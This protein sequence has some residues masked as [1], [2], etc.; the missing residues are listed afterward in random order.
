M[1]TLLHWKCP[2]AHQRC[3]LWLNLVSMW[4]QHMKIWR[5]VI[6]LSMCICQVSLDTAGV[7]QV[8]FLCP[9]SAYPNVFLHVSKF[10]LRYA[11]APQW[12]TK[13]ISLKYKAFKLLLSLCLCLSS[14]CGVGISQHRPVLNK[15]AGV[16]FFPFVAVVFVAC[17]WWEMTFVT[18]LPPSMPLGFAVIL[19]K[20]SGEA[21]TGFSGACI[22]WLVTVGQYNFYWYCFKMPT[23][24]KQNCEI[25][26]AC[27][28]HRW[29]KLISVS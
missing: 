29:L 11:S 13:L 10:N 18:A 7:D 1:K 28:A 12:L 21:V 20:I 19:I 15:L 14:L 25:G 22:E 24:M 8:L 4:F 9:F 6:M 3:K 17:Y 16:L 23:L 26:G 5:H 2:K 27:W